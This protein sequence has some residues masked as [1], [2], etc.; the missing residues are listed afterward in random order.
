MCGIV[1]IIAKQNNVVDKIIK[2]LKQLEYRGYD[3]A[4]IAILDN[5]QILIRKSLGNITQL[6]QKITPDFT[7]NLGIAH[8]R[9]ATHGDVSEN[10]AHPH[11]SCKHNIVLVHNGIIEN[12]REL[13]LFL[14]RYGYSF[15]SQT[16]TEVIPN[17]ILYY[18]E[19]GYDI[20]D[21]FIK[22]LSSLK[23]SYAL[24]MFCNATKK[25]FVAK[26]NSPLL[27]GIGSDEY[28]VAS[29]S[30][31][32]S[33][34]TNKIIELEDGEFGIIDDESYIFYNSLGKEIKKHIKNINI[35]DFLLDKGQFPTF[36]LKEIY[37]EPEVIKRLINKYLSNKNIL[38]NIDQ[39]SKCNYLNIVGC[40]TSY[41]AG[42][43]AKYFFERIANVF[44]NTDIA[45]EFRYRSTP[46]FQDSVN[47]FISQSGET[48]DT[49]AALKYCKSSCQKIVSLVNANNSTIGGLSNT[50]LSTMSGIEIGVASTKAF[51]GQITVLYLLSLKLAKNRG[52][53]SYKEY[54]NRITSITETQDRLKNIL[55]NEKLIE[56]IKFISQKLSL[57]EHIMYV[58]RDVFY[59]IVLEGALKMKEISYIPTDGLA[60]GELKHGPIALISD[61]SYV[62]F[63]VFDTFLLEKNLSNI[64]EIIARNGK[65]IVITS[66]K[67][68]SLLSDKIS[69]CITLPDA[70]DD[71][72][73]IAQTTIVLQL[74]AYY[75]ACFK[76][77]DVD[78]PR[79]LAKS[80]TV[81]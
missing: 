33:G 55:Y 21:A 56:N 18:L 59:P 9:W 47:I 24:A 60:A 16:D 68:T 52:L 2:S 29:G 8:T 53:I 62:V 72:I 78:K 61:K 30:T 77:N 14:E 41:Y 66:S 80:V 13:K 45:S 74:L 1:G 64:E 12:Y 22:A 4:G 69:Y 23:G 54:N 48:A 35:D 27:I 38:I 43:V 58:A 73:N 10:N 71:Y 51:L 15:T 49:L 3:S 11:V 44:V 25:L 70:M 32:F 50:T 34:L 63:V 46:L 76:G 7:A 40:G 42:C 6:E 65:V 28:Y 17:L 20:D 67:I 79:N 31:A 26:N 81:E 39:W 19:S 57:C 37:E 5:T 75:C 36:M